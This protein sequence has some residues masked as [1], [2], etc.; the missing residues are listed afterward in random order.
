MQRGGAR[1]GAGRKSTWAS[2]CKRKDTQSIRIPIYLKDQILSIAHKL[3]AGKAIEYDANS[4]K[5]ENIK[6]KARIQQLENELKEAEKM[7]VFMRKDLLV[8][9]GYK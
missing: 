8:A 6:L 3:D 4:K 7:I 1:K 5:A 9:R 2:G